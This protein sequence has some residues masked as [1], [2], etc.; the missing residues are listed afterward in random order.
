MSTLVL[1]TS[2]TLLYI[3]L[4]LRFLDVISNVQKIIGKDSTEN[5]GITFTQTH[6]LYLTPLLSLHEFFSLIM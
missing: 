5:S 4:L 1:H 2:N 3:Y 6:H